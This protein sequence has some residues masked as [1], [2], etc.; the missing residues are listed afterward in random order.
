MGQFPPSGLNF[1]SGREL[2]VVLAGH[3]FGKN[4][5][6][7]P[8]PRTSPPRRRSSTARGAIDAGKTGEH[9]GQDEKAHGTARRRVA[10]RAVQGSGPKLPTLELPWRQSRLPWR[11]D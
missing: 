10:G 6:K 8:R 3:L 9:G 5:T 2:V 11:L 4:D 1:K 7:H